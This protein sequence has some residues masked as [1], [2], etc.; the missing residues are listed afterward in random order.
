M[1]NDETGPRRASTRDERRQYLMDMLEQL[2]AVAVGCGE[3]DIADVLYALVEVH[4]DK[5]SGDATGA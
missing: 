1:S 2:A 4:R 3:K 5:G